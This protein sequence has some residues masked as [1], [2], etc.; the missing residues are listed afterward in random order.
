MEKLEALDKHKHTYLIL[1]CVNH[2]GAGYLCSVSSAKRRRKRMSEAK[3]SEEN[4]W[5][6]VGM[7]VCVF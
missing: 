4:E 5:M 2:G 6:S 7:H 1:R 3:S